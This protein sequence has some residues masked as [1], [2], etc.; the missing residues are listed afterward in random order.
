MRNKELV[1]SFKKIL[2]EEFAKN[3]ALNRR[4]V[5][6]RVI[7]ESRPRFYVSYN[8]AYKVLTSA[9]IHGFN[10]HRLSLRQQMWRELL[11][12]VETEMQEHPFLNFGHA[13]ARVLAEKRAS[14][15]YLSPEYCYKY[16]YNIA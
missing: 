5:V 4:R 10:S 6:Q 9:R 7:H 16:L 15:F 12:L 2:K 3:E 8:R 11:M 1:A 13:L 14:R